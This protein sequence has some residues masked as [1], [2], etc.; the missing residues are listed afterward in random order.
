MTAEDVRA[1]RNL[2]K[3]LTECEERTR[4]LEN[5]MK[6]KVGLR[7]VE[8]YVNK[9]REKLRNGEKF[10][11]KSEIV[12][13]VM[14]AKFRDNISF[15]IRLRKRKN[16]FKVKLEK[17]LGQ[18]S[19]KYRKIVR[20]CKEER[21]RLRKTLRKKYTK[22]CQ[23]LVRKYG[24]RDDEKYGMDD[25]EMRRY[26]D[27]EIF[28]DPCDM[29]ADKLRGPVIVCGDGEDKISLNE[30]EMRFLALG[31]K[32]C[33]YNKLCEVG[34]EESIEEGIV[35]LKWDWMGE[36]MDNR[37]KPKSL[38]DMAISVAL[39][40]LMTEE[41]KEEMRQEE[42]INEAKMRMV[43]DVGE[44]T[45]TY[46]KKRVTDFK[47]NA[48]V[49]LPKKSKNFDREATLEMLRVELMSEFKKYVETSGMRMESNLSIEERRGLKSLRKRVNEGDLVIVPTD[50]SGRFVCMKRRCMRQLDKNTVGKMRW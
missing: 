44:K 21:E 2:S 3:K 29:V 8:E 32:F 22:K 40:E 12:N 33:M 37:K 43:Y 47:G 49:I 30:D 45:I 26:K 17:T 9:E 38:S 28:N 6:C 15:G 4:M 35:K 46:T 27:A 19:C 23:F 13:G 24:N 5:L 50:K 41:E 10:S 11:P 34:F 36:E 16:I 31:P 25:K 42:E 39:D 1:F 14:K 18:Q 7:E 20:E 48:R